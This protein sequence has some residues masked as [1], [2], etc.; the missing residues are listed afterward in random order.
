MTTFRLRHFLS[1]LVVVCAPFR[2]SRSLQEVSSSV[3]GGL[4]SSRDP[5]AQNGGLRAL[6]EVWMTTFFRSRNCSVKS[7]R[8]LN[9]FG[10][11]Q[12]DEDEEEEEEE[13]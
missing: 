13:E 3:Q 11:V 8:F 4:R 7:G 6:E 9:P 5:R 2:A 12:E 10:R 1:S